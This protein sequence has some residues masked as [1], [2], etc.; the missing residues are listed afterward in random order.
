MAVDNNLKELRE[1]L[2]YSQKGS[3]YA[4]G[5]SEKKQSEISKQTDLAP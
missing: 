3:A 4:I 1:S 2:D 5:V